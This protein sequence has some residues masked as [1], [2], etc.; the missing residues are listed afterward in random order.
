MVDFVERRIQT[1]GNTTNFNIDRKQPYIDTQKNGQTVRIYGT[2][3]QLDRYQSKK[4]DGTP[5]QTDPSAISVTSGSASVTT[6]Q[7]PLGVI[8]QITNG[9]GEKFKKDSSKTGV[10]GGLNLENIVSNPLEKFASYSPLWTLAVLTPEQFNNP[11]LY[12][13][14]GFSFAGDFDIDF[15]T[16]ETIEKNY[17]IFSSGGRAD[18]QR[19]KTYYG[20]PEYFVDNFVMR[21]VIS[22]T[23]AT[24]N[25]NAIKFEFDI[26]EPYSMGLFLQSLQ[27]AALK[28]GYANYLDNCPY[29]LRL[30]F[31]GFSDTGQEITSLKPKYFVM[32]L[33]GVKF[34]VDAGG[35]T[36]KVE[37]IPYNHQAFSDAVNTV[38]TDIAIKAGS[39]G[40]VEELLVSGE[41]SLCAV[42]N[43]NEQKLVNEKRISVADVYEVQFPEKSSDFISTQK[44]P[45]TK[46][47]TKNVKGDSAR[48]V[49]K[50]TDVE[51]N[52]D[53]GNNPI[54]KSTFGFSSGDGGNFIFKKEGDVVDE[55]TGKVQRD[56][57][58]IDP[59]SRTFMFGQG[60]SLT[61]I[62]S[63]V[64]LSSVYA[65]NAIN[66]PVNEDG[67]I[68]WF[69]IDIQIEFLDFDALVGDY[70]KKIIFRV[71]PFLVHHSIFSNP[72]SAP[73]GYGQ[74]EKKIAKRYE[75]IYTG[76]NADILNFDIQI[77][78]LFYT[79]VNP[80]AEGNTASEVNPDQQGTAPE[81]GQKTETPEGQAPETQAAYT[82]RAR[83]LADPNN[84]K[85][86]FRGGS[87]VKDT[88][89][90]IAESF[91]NAFINGSSADLVNLDLEILGDPYWMVDSGMANYFSETNEPTD[92]INADGTMNY[93]GSDV[94]IYI[95]FRTPADVDVATGMY[96]FAVNQ[97]ESPF[98]GIYRVTMC[99]NVFSEGTFKQKLTCIR[100]PGQ[101]QDYDGEVAQT[102]PATATAVA[103]TGPKPVPSSPT[104]DSIT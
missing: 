25:S 90:M 100:M 42:L 50:G 14:D 95:S 78:N 30:D 57:M 77:N 27:N 61:E 73:L 24:G 66:P 88:E 49:I 47:A 17:I 12:R 19:T 36:Y 23:P 2:Q 74:L 71:V 55:V 53:F 32:K 21:S 92:L 7:D 62:I 45:I 43:R 68:R 9:N 3:E 35:S 46:G 101:P 54:G 82:G 59:K 69:R 63:Q 33:S 96:K 20:T 22:A 97:K 18:E 28:A 104:D 83:P 15:E 79:G 34:E 60:Q 64:V 72:N 56:R 75:Y 8:N 11:A 10:K 6:N 93:E 91:H 52:T 89:Q 13:T 26:Y 87:G 76:Q 81:P 39:K 102:D 94:Y 85:P 99:E 58:T 1:N 16:G 29:L 103:I 4:P 38:F 37:A 51:V 98:S 31:K 40:T 86:K 67:F 48:K 70:A 44:L 80:S 41:E 5:T 65:K 84:L